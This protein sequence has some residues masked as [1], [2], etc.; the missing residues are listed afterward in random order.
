MS[1]KDGREPRDQ[2]FTASGITVRVLPFPMIIYDRIQADMIEM[3]PDPIAPKK[4]IDTLGGKEEVDDTE[5]EGYKR[6]LAEVNVSRNDYVA[7]RYIQ[8]LLS[9]CLEIDID[10]YK[11]ELE[12]FLRYLGKSGLDVPDNEYDLREEFLSQFV[13]RK[14][15]DYRRVLSLAL[16]QATITGEEVAAR[17]NSFQGDVEQPATDDAQAS[18]ADG[19]EQV[20]MEPEAA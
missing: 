13:L 5:D 9:L 3:F 7:R 4:Q 10:A 18:G 12:K 15:S 16:R 6:E 19:A 17:I 2:E 14:R 11:G 20:E 8:T 1:K